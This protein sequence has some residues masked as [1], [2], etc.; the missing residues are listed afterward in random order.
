MLEENPDDAEAVHWLLR[1]GTAQNRW[2]ELSRHLRKYLLRNPG[3]LAIR[4]ALG[5]VLVRGEQIEGARQEYEAL[6]ALEPTF[7]GLS[8][9]GQAISAKQAV[10]MMESAHS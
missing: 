6:R 10:S 5:G 9:L 3:N 7:D 2:E 1:A 4:F 8:E